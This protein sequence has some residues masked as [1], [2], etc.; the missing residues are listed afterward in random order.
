[1]LSLG[2]AMARQSSIV[3]LCVATLARATLFPK[4][5]QTP[6][7]PQHGLHVETANLSGNYWLG[8]VNHSLSKSIYDSS[9]VVYRNVKDFGAK[10]DGSSDDTKAIQKAISCM[11]RPKAEDIRLTTFSGQPMRRL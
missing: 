2:V 5:L 8:A 10:G 11:S 9:Y 1:M 6:L 3:L 7:F 4:G